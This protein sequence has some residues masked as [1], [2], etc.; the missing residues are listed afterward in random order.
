LLVEI[1]HIPSPSLKPKSCPSGHPNVVLD[2]DRDSTLI[3]H[4]R[5]CATDMPKARTLETKEEDST[6]EHESF[7]FET[8]HVPHSLVESPG[9]IVLSTTYFYR[10]D[11]YP[12]LLICKLFK[13]MVIDVFIYHKYYRSCSCNVAPTL[14]LE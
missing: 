4:E 1:E 3:L 2:S 7:S 11:N 13:M 8:S 14:Q 6:N 5:F 10:E 9:F 12:S